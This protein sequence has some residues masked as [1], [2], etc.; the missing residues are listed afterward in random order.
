MSDLRP[1]ATLVKAGDARTVDLRERLDD[2]YRN[3]ESYDAYLEGSH[4]PEFWDVIKTRID[5]VLKRSGTCAVLEVGAGRSG[6]GPY[7]GENRS[8]ITYSVQDVVAANLEYLEQV[9]D[10]VVVGPVQALSGQYDIVLM[11][12]VLEHMTDPEA[13]L[14]HLASLLTPDGR[15]FSVSPRYDNPFY[16]PPSARHLPLVDRIRLMGRITVSRAHTA[17]SGRGRFLIHLRPAVLEVPWYR[18]ADAIHWPSKYDLL[19]MGL[20]MVMHAPTQPQQSWKYRTWAKTCLLFVELGPPSKVT[21]NDMQQDA[22]SVAT[23]PVAVRAAAAAFHSQVSKLKDLVP[24]AWRRAVKLGRA[25]IARR[26]GTEMFATP[27]LLNLDEALAKYLP[28]SGTFVELGANDGY[29]Q[30]NT[31]YLE[32]VRGWRGVLIEPIPQLASKCR[33]MRP[34]SVVFNVACVGES[35]RRFITIEDS[36]LMSVALGQQDVSSELSRLQGGIRHVVPAAQLSQV[37]EA[38]GLRRPTFVSLDVEGAELDVLRGLRPEHYPDWLLVETEHPDAVQ[39]ALGESMQLVRQLTFHDYLYA[40]VE[41][42]VYLREE[43]SCT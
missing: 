14:R 28:A 6:F 17:V 26:I 4:A 19:T 1:R 37:L 7:L 11:T 39:A 43:G 36:D 27:G 30:S 34:G 33:V 35:D 18:D 31:Y 25:R 2:F 16:V 13:A 10:H 29:S 38:A 40:R 32:M 42:G 5:D 8:R 3:T 20:P 24:P 12:F 41:T 15:I 21:G 22:S 23:R 9:A